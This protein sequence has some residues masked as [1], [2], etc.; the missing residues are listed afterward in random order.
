V[1]TLFNQIFKPAFAQIFGKI[2]PPPGVKNYGGEPG[3]GLFIFLNN[4]MKLIIVAA[5]LFA[6]LNFILAGFEFVSAG[7][8]SEKISKAWAK[9]WQSLVGLL[10]AAG[11]FTLAAVFG[12]IIFGDFDAIINPNIYGP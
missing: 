5:G 4:L 7:G 1:S 11:S 12:K 6:L 3:E 8:D 9:I 10:I 2:E